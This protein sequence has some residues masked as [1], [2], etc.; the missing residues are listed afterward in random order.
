MFFRS[1]KKS[2]LGNRLSRNSFSRGRWTYREPFL[3]SLW[4]FVFA[5]VGGYCLALGFAPH[6]GYNLLSLIFGTAVYQYLVIRSLRLEVVGF[7]EVGWFQKT[8]SRLVPYLC[9]IFFVACTL[10]WFTESIN[11]YGNF[12]YG[13]SLAIVSLVALGLSVRTFL[14]KLVFAFTYKLLR[15][16]HAWLLPLIITLCNYV[17]YSWVVNFE[18]LNFAYA[19]VNFLAQATA[20]LGGIN[21]TQLVYLYLGLG[22]AL[23]FKTMSRPLANIGTSIYDKLAVA[24]IVV[25]A[26]LSFFYRPMFTHPD[27]KPVYVALS[28]PNLDPRGKWDVNSLQAQ[29]ELFER[30]IDKVIAHGQELPEQATNLIVFPESAIGV[31]FRHV[32]EVYTYYLDKLAPLGIN[33]ITGSMNHPYNSAILFTPH[34]MQLN[35]FTKQLPSGVKQ[36]PF[37][38]YYMQVFHKKNLVPFGEYLPFASFLADKHPF[39][40]AL[41]SFGIERGDVQQGNFTSSFGNFGVLICYDALFN[42]QVLN[43]V[44]ATTGALVTI[45]NDVWFGN[46]AGPFQ[47]F[48]IIR[49]RALEQ[50]KPIV[51]STNN[52][53]TAVI[54]AD[55]SVK[56]QLPRNEENLLFSSFEKHYGLTPYTATHGWSVIYF[57]IGFMLWILISGYCYHRLVREKEMKFG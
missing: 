33:L 40:T 43:D 10:S 19:E 54:N 45:S 20:P 16:Y 7:D 17:W 30:E 21:L 26:L 46:S 28:Q 36:L 57:V 53:I 44:I 15:K 29:A 42:Y 34:L 14:V 56:D 48:N 4:H 27:G 6:N 11:F 41:N 9:D 3:S 38:S 47:H 2:R 55:G 49:Y 1:T 39:F 52:G 25:F 13:N 22:L 23:V 35:S 5:L 24:T 50:Q 51:R 37:G 8:L 12:G 32:E 31:D 18:W